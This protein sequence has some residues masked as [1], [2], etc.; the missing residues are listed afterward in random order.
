M[1]RFD[2]NNQLVGLIHIVRDITDR[3]RIEE[4]IKRAKDELEIRV[5]NRTSELRIVNEQLREEIAERKRIEE[6]LRRSENEFRSLS[7]EFN[8]L[9][10]AIPDNLILLSPE[11]KVM[12]SNRAATSGMGINIS[13]MKGQYCYKLCCNLT[14]PCKDCP[15][16]RS[17]HTG[18]AE[19]N[20]VSTPHGRLWNIRAFPIKDESGKVKN[21]IEVATDIT[22]RVIL[23]TE[24]MRT[25]QLASLGELAAGVA[26]E[27]NNPINNIINYAQILLDE[28]NKENKDN[29]ILHRMIK[30]GDRIATIVRS[31][32]SFARIKKKEKSI[33]DLHEIFSD[34]FSLIA[35]QIH[36]DGIN[37][38]VDIFPDPVK[39]FAHPQ[40]IQQ[41]FLN[42][43]SN[44][45][46]ALNEKYPG[47]H[48]NKILYIIC[49]K[50][51]I[52]NNPWVRVIFHDRGTGIPANIFDKVMNPFF[53]TKPSSVGTGLGLSISHGII[54]EHGGKLM[55]D[56]IEGE[57]TKVTIELPV[58]REN[59]K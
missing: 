11:L 13:E 53:S 38:K 4:E 24:T 29:D 48:K 35:A 52:D 49:E 28:Y 22:E 32:L 25:R 2:D 45:R 30:D 54:S 14:S 55:I 16:I 46:F 27:I 37:L 18:K 6:T 21:V 12:W 43:I 7:Q 23:Q 26:H 40:Q 51:T 9:L 50:T 15:A 59:E 36:K 10:D 44:S 31:L 39:I 1:P 19:N 8:I 3:K 42:I 20:Q 58:K 33:V 17:F 34:M 41:V 47:I 57:F 5:E 56:S